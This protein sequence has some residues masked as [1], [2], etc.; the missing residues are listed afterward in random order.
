MTLAA[1]RPNSSRPLAVLVLAVGAGVLATAYASQYLGGLAPCELCLYQRWPWWAAGGLALIAATAPVAANRR[2][3][4]CLTAGLF[5]LAGAALAAY[6][7]GVEQH[8]WQGPASCGGG[9]MPATLAEMQ[10]AMATPIVPCDEPAWSL[11]GV[12]MAGYNAVFSLV[13]GGFVIARS[14]SRPR[15]AG[16]R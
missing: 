10:R 7:V 12:S 5:I 14:L 1:L 6:H 3:G 9:A 13:F 15:R 16:A 8:W 2:R 11:F 4:L